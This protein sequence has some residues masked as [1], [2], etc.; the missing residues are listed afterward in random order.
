MYE[1]LSVPPKRSLQAWRMVI[2]GLA[3]DD[4]SFLLLFVF[5]GFVFLCCV[6]FFLV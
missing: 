4:V 1:Y 2:N 3:A 5:G 6:V